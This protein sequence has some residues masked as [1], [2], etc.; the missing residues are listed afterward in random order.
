[1]LVVRILADEK[2][3]GVAPSTVRLA[4]TET[5]VQEIAKSA[6]GVHGPLKILKHFSILVCFNSVLTA[7][8]SLWN[9]S[10]SGGNA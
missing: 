7:T 2:L 8:P 6:P 1:M 10:E 9:L 5:L 3:G 4:V